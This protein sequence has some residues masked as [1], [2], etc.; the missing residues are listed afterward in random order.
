MADVALIWDPALGR[1]DMALA[2][3]DLAMDDG[4]ETAV[5]IS[6]FTDA[7]ADA[8]DAIPDGSGDPRGWWGDLPIDAGEQGAT[9]P[10]VTGSKLWLLDRAL[11]TR[12]TL[13]RAES[14]AKAALAWMVRDGVAQSVNATAV[15]RSLGVLELTV[16]IEQDGATRQ[17]TYAWSVTGPAP[18]IAP[19]S[20]IVL[21]ARPSNATFLDAAG[22]LVEVGPNVLRPLFVA[23]AQVGN[24]VE[25]AATNYVRNPRAEGAVAGT[26][27]TTPPDWG[28][29]FGTGLTGSI[30]GSGTY[31]GV[32]YL[33]IGVSGTMG[34]TG[35]GL[36][37]N[38]YLDNSNAEVVNGD[39]WTESCWAQIVSGTLPAGQTL[40]LQMGQY[41]GTTEYPGLI[42]ATPYAW[43]RYANPQVITGGNTSADAMV[44]VYANAGQ[45]VDLTLR[46]G[47]PQFEKGAPATSLILPPAGS[48]GSSTRAADT[49]WSPG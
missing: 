38:V 14:Y 19:P 39:T 45:V 2:A 46:I 22:A 23:G 28:I 8:G 43:T 24:L 29:S 3:G 11:L 20:T 42:C 12:E 10:D 21:D 9:P 5:V 1:A 37:I 49:I 4:L 7:P 18:G 41:G 32:P 47:G 48:P 17:F 35:T 27:G 31:N 36:A 40:S 16:T 44:W 30:V 33:D 25:A 34:G 6:L 15:S 26:P 13:A